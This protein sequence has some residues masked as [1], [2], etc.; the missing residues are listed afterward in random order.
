MRNGQ[1]CDYCGQETYS[2]RTH[3]IPR[4]IGDFGT[5]EPLGDLLRSCDLC[6]ACEAQREQDIRLFIEGHP[7]TP[8][9]CTGGM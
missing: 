5:K 1:T 9:V 2:T 8:L 7:A 3:L 4:I 6:R